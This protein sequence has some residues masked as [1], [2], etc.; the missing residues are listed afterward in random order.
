MILEEMI[1]SNG[2]ILQRCQW[3]FRYREQL[4]RK[5][6]KSA[7]EAAKR[8][9]TIKRNRCSRKT[10]ITAHARPKYAKMFLVSDRRLQR[11]TEF[12]NDHPVEVVAVV[13]HTIPIIQD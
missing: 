12:T 13:V 11:A 10:E 1:R 9:L 6:V 4:F 8:V 3:I 2:L 5:A 7:H